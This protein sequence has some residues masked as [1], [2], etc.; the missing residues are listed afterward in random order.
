M[1]DEP[2][3]TTTAQSPKLNGWEAEFAHWRVLMGS[4]TYGSMSV[5]WENRLDMER[6]RD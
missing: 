4:P 3:R 6:L 5:D 1:P 2:A